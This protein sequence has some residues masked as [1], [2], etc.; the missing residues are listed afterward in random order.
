MGVVGLA[1]HTMDLTTGSVTKKFLLFTL[2]I[3]ASNLLQ[4]F[5]NAADT[6]VVGKFASETALAAVGSTGSLITLILSLFTGLS[7]GTNVACANHF[8]AKNQDKLR[9]CMH[10]SLLLGLVCGIGLMAVGVAFARPLQVMMG[11]PYNVIDQATLYIRIYFLGVPASL[12]YNFASAILRAHGDTKRPMILLALSGIVNVLLNLLFV[13]VFHMDVEGVALATIISQYLS[14]AAALYL[15]FDPKGDCAMK[16][17]ELK[18]NGESVEE[19]VRIGVP[20]GINGIVFSL[21][22]VILQ[23]TVNSFGDVIMA[24]NSVSGSISGFVCLIAATFSNAC[25]SFAGQCCGAKQYKRIDS[26]LLNSIACSVIG[27]CAASLLVTLIPR[28][29]LGLYTNNPDVIDNAVERMVM[30]SWGYVLYAVGESTSGCLRGMGYS[31]MPTVLNICGICLPRVLWVFFIFPL[32]PTF[33]VLN[34]CYPVSWFVS[35]VMQVIYYLHC[36]KKKQA[37]FAA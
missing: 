37:L 27:V 10:V 11:S 26:L 1:K 14:M 35:A 30:V 23:S 15:L 31:T 36:R 28:V 32:N 21:S 2:P 33:F 24:A 29:L 13:M 19:I 4:Q 18:M 8:G 25:V 6:M 7:A 5:Y 17:R 16:K 34:I 20:T 3:L 12:L 22:N 9:A